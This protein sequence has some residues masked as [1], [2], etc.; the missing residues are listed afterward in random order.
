M[1][2]GRNLHEEPAIPNYGKPGKGARLEV[3]MTLAIEPM[4][5]MG[6][7]KVIRVKR[8]MD[9]CNKRQ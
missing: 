2:Y 7:E 4:V 3:G 5:N 6:K 9:N 1:V 8:W